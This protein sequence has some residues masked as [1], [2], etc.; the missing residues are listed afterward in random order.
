[1]KKAEA[2]AYARG[3]TP[4]REFSA[5]YMD[6]RNLRGILQK[7]PDCADY[8][9]LK[10]V[11][12]VIIEQRYSDQ[13]MSR[14][15]YRECAKTLAAVGAASSD[16][17]LSSQAL[18]LQVQAAS[19]C[20]EHASIEASAGLGVLP[21]ELVLPEAPT[22]FSGYAPSI[23]W[24]ELIKRGEALE[25]PTFSGRSA[26]MK[27]AGDDQIFAIKIAREGEI[28]DGLHLEGKWTEKLTGF[29]KNCEVRFDCPRPFGV[30]GQV[31]FKVT[32]LP[33]DAPSNLH[34][35]GYAMAYHAHSDY[36]VY[37]ND[38]REGRRSDKD[39]FLEIMSRNTFILGQ[40]AGKG[41]VHDAPIPLFHNR[42]QAL[43]RTDEGVYEWHKFGRLDRWL[44]SCRFPNFGLSGLRDFEHLQIMKPG[45]D[46]FYR[47]VGSHFMSILLVIGSWFRAQNPEMCGLDKNDEPIDARE[48]FDADFFEVAVMDCFKEYYRGFTGS[49]FQNEIELHPAKLVKS[50]I[51]EMGVDRHMFEVMRIVDQ[52]ILDD[53][54]FRD[55]LLKY[56]MDPAKVSE[57]KKDEADVPLVTGPHL[58]DFNGAISL[59]E[60]VE[61][62]AMAAGCCIAAKSLGS[63]WIG[64]RLG[65]V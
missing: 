20:S 17:E 51:E 29:S 26:V 63:R 21:F 11:W 46:K 45:S 39:D 34:K 37:P 60:I 36:F 64:V 25:V 14:L 41:I 4:E 18:S 1:M 15:L 52:K 13:T 65:E 2:T 33:A 50:M 44:E 7:S 12:D 23:T 24:D 55:Y 42:V 54:E 61:W 56:G 8:S 48:L 43:R 40:L 47:G 3:L 32:N 53:Q 38:D 62:S 57:L 28:P 49:E 27:S 10:A 31:V 5:A 30:A 6:L 59:P 19:T 16:S 9:I 35:D 22:N 58:G